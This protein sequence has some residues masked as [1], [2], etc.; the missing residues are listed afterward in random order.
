VNAILDRESP[1]VCI[2]PTSG[3]KSA[4]IMIP[5]IL[6]SGRT[7]I[8][9]TSYI[10][11]AN[12]FVRQCKEAGI[13]CI[14]WERG[15]T[16]VK[17]A[18]IVIVVLETGISAD[19][20]TYA[21]DLI[22]Q[23]LLARTYVDEA[24]VLINDLLFRPLLQKYRNISLSVQTIHLT[25]TFP[26]TITRLYEIQQLLTDLS[27]TYIRASTNRSNVHYHVRRIG[28]SKLL[29]GVRELINQTLEK[30]EPGEKILVFCK[31]Y[32]SVRQVAALVSSAFTYFGKN[33]DN[34][35]NL[36]RWIEGE[37]PIMIATTGLGAGVN[38]KRIKLVLH[39]DL[40]WSCTAFLQE[41]GRGGRSGE[42]FDS[43]TLISSERYNKLLEMDPEELNPEDRAL[44]EFLTTLRCLRIPLSK[45][46]DGDNNVVD[47]ITSGSALCRNCQHAD[48]LSR[49]RL[50]EH[51]EQEEDQRRK[52]QAYVRDN[53]IHDSVATR[54]QTLETIQ[55]IADRLHDACSHCWFGQFYDRYENHI[56]QACVRRADY[57]AALLTVQ[58]A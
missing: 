1:L 5:A 45:F 35:R 16:G 11:L 50:R 7:N 51:E 12:D 27:P 32:K 55:D 48:A 43:V 28:A 30:I 40:T 56:D 14:R 25:A 46:M 4:L 33:E 29:N 54:Q 38:I 23:G 20:V 53:V 37:R 19:F 22:S 24:Q 41:S 36:H 47:C 2:L 57:Q 49:K 9:F 21:R 31:S 52:K 42:Q 44:R 6:E 10:A 3:G 39:V 17:R 18:S 13:D 8:V 15:K 26:P 58:F 34:S